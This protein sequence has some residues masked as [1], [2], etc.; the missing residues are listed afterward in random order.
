M[1]DTVW[2]EARII[3][4]VRNGGMRWREAAACLRRA[5][6]DPEMV[7][8]VDSSSNDGSDAVAAAQ[9]FKLH[10][11]DVR[12]F[13]HGKTRDL[14]VR[15]FCGDKPFVIFAT[16]DA[17]VDGPQALTNLLHSF[18]DEKV[19]AA[20]GRQMPHTGAQSFE[21]HAALFNYAPTSETRTLADAGRLGIKAAFFSNSF[22]AYRVAALQECGGFP[23][24]LILGEDAFVAM[25]MLMSGWS[26]RYVAEARVR[27]SHAYTILQ[28]AQRYFDFGVMH[29]Q[30]PE[31]LQTF[32]APEG[33]GIRFVISELRYV[34]RRS[35]W[36]LPEVAIRN[37][38]K[39]AGY[40]LGRSFRRLP[41]GLCLRLS[42]TKLYW[43]YTPVEEGSAT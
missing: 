3:V 31:L 13:N 12:T 36:L 11:I 8:V 18:R 24:H 37:A 20:Y 30:I 10:R 38:A 6:P 1:N 27:H 29:A 14:A 25:R 4:P 21:A 5:V 2:K 16:Q 9:G 34:G 23:D 26:V 22:A 28:E 19:G 32:G 39:Y 35:P 43:Q 40:R 17:I 7:V 15:D 42:M 33:E 41:R